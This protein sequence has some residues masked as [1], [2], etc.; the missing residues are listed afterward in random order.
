MLRESTFYLFEKILSRNRRVLCLCYSIPRSINDA[1]TK[2]WRVNRRYIKPKNKR[3]V[4]TKSGKTVQ[5]IFFSLQWKDIKVDALICIKLTLNKFSY[6]Y[7]GWVTTE[8]ILKIELV[9]LLYSRTMI[10]C[11]VLS[12]HQQVL[13]S[14]TLCAG[15]VMKISFKILNS[16]RARILQSRQ[17]RVLLEE[18]QM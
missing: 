6:L 13:C 2:L 9:L 3:V 12:V 8:S 5:W 11:R 4:N 18:T 17:F 15:D 1:K 14:K 10:I 16:L 7:T